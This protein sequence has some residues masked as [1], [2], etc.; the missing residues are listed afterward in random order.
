MRAVGLDPANAATAV[1]RDL[2]VFVELHVEQGPVLEDH[3]PRLGVVT[4]I[5][6]TAHLEITV[7]GQADHAGAMAMDRRKDAFLGASAMSLAI[8]DAAVRMGHPAVAT[9]GTIEVEPSQVNV[10]P[11]LARFTVTS[12]PEPSRRRS[13]HR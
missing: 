13:H 1:R 2:D 5:A 10:V 6:G 3:G 8:A 11:G 12:T 7:R 9:V 4:T